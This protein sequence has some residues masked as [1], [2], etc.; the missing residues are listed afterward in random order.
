MP[1][2]PE[3]ETTLNGIRPFLEGTTIDRLVV[4]QRKLRWRIPR[5]LEHEIEKADV[6]KLQ[7][8]GKYI[9]IHLTKGGLII[10]L[11]MSGSIRVLLQNETPGK[12]DHF[13][14]V[15]HEG[16]IIRYCDPRKFG[17]LLYCE[18]DLLMHPRLA[19]LGVEPLENDFTADYLYQAS[20]NRGVS[21]KSF[22]MNGQIVVG[23]G[24]IY[25]S[26]AL[27]MAGIHPGRLAG[28]TTFKR[29]EKLVDAIKIILH[30]AIIK[31]GTTLQD[32]VGVDG[33]PGYFEQSLTVYGREGDSCLQ[34]KAPIKKML[35][36]Q[37][38]T[39]YCPRCQR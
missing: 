13:D 18:E 26:E 1:E 15:N 38:S 22:I 24:N 29:Y 39:F 37:R 32:F 4:R 3:V 6:I 2:L 12:H 31:G 20:R 30:R 9:L 17:C 7:R 16:Q 33:S 27:F 19:N 34:C 28:K 8:R 25:A 35:T 11:G 21:I 10:H 36:G 23:V 5:G 14:L